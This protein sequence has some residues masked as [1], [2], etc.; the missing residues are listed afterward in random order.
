MSWLCIDLDELPA[1][2]RDLKWFGHN[3]RALL[4]INDA[5]Y[6]GPGAGAIRD[7]VIGLLAR[8]GVS[9]PIARI[10]LI[11]LPRVLG[12]VFNPVSFFRCHRD[13]GQLAAL[14]G[15][16]RNTF[17]ETHHYVLPRPGN[18]TPAT[19]IRFR[20]PKR[21]Y[22]SPFNC[23]EGVYELQL[24][25]AVNSLWL[26]IE[27]WQDERRVMSAGMSGDGVPM[28]MRNMTASAI[29]FPFTVAGVMPRITW[30]ALQ[31]YLRKRT[32]TFE[33]SNPISP[34]TIAAT[35]SSV[36]HRGREYLVRL[37]SAGTGK[38]RSTASIFASAKE[39]LP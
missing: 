22:V 9:V 32:I 38:Q 23:A 31:L 1:L 35:R 10:D 24:D 5:D 11:T 37:A 26:Q 13:D 15:E 29:R 7:K 18:T 39:S 25:D 34:A 20:F 28:N 36:W 21:F 3:R 6:G 16:V 33:K 4:S 8:E 14:V 2:D 30:Q 27:L 17:G 12:Y 19:P